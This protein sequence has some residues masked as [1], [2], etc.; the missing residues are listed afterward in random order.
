MNKLKELRLGPLW[1][2]PGV[3]GVNLGTMLFAAFGTMAMV[4]F[5][6][7]MQP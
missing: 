1:F 5:M 7:F 2:E 6:S 4:T 3:N